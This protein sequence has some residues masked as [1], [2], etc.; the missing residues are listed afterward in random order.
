MIDFL[1]LSLNI[2]LGT[3]KTSQLDGSLWYPQHMF[4]LRNQKIN[5]EL[6]LG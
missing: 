4:Q 1:S 5:V 3:S 6:P 2:W